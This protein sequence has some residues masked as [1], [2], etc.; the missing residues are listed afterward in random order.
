MRG[1]GYLAEFPDLPGCMADGE[2]VKEALRQAEDALAAWLAAAKEFG[3][4][5]SAPSAI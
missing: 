4:P 1:G 2:T 3:D 5:I